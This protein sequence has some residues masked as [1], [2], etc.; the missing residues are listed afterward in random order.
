MR[1]KK[2][3]QLLA[4][5]TGSVN[6]KLLLQVEYLAAENRILRAK[7]PSRLRLSDHSA[8]CWLQIGSGCPHRET[9]AWPRADFLDNRGTGRG[10]RAHEGASPAQQTQ[11]R[12]RSVT[13]LS[14]ADSPHHRERPANAFPAKM[15]LQ[16]RNWLGKC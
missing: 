11:D 13:A 14:P 8:R 1:N 10:D 6:Q 9:G 4:Y 15:Q 3:L 2:W 7:L 5:V 12:L 16:N